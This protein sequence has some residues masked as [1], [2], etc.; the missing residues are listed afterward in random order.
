MKGELKIQQTQIVFKVE[1]RVK[2]LKKRGII[3]NNRV[4]NDYTS[5]L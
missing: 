5:N 1:K 2:L 4:I 3:A